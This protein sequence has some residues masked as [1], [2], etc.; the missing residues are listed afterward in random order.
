LKLFHVSI[1]LFLSKPGR[2]LENLQS[3]IC[4][5]LID[6]IMKL[7]EE[8]EEEKQPKYEN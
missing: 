3:D 5:G 4:Y 6:S 7:G 2:L 1:I 8:E